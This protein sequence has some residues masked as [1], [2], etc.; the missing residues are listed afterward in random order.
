MGYPAPDTHIKCPAF[1]SRLKRQWFY[2]TASPVR[3]AVTGRLIYFQKRFRCN[4][5]ERNWRWELKPPIGRLLSLRS[6]N[7]PAVWVGFG[8]F[9]LIPTFNRLNYLHGWSVQKVKQVANT[10][11]YL[12]IGNRNPP[13]LVQV[14]PYGAQETPPIRC[15]SGGCVQIMKLY[16]WFRLMRDSDQYLLI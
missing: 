16:W 1:Q 5:E 12:P 10:Q 4:W 13:F 3:P 15:S 14:F 7:V 8:E 6:N 11:L 9:C 2:F